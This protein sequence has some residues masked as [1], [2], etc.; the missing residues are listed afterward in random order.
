MCYLLQQNLQMHGLMFIIYQN[1]F[2]CIC[3]LIKI[4]EYFAQVSNRNNLSFLTPHLY[5]ND[6]YLSSS[7]P[8]TYEDF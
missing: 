1:G 5:F 6:K 8:T 4:M 2:L 7:F 3:L